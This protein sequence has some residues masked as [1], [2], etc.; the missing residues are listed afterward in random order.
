MKFK[1][2]IPVVLSFCFSVSGQ[3][4]GEFNPGQ[5]S[6]EIRYDVINGTLNNAGRIIASPIKFKLREWAYTGAAAGVIALSFTQDDFFYSSLRGRD[7]S[8]FSSVANYIGEPF[9]N[10][11]WTTG[12]SL[13]LYLLG[14]GFKK[15]RLSEPALIAFQ[16]VAIS[17]SSALFFKLLFHRQR[18]N[19]GTAPDS[20][21]W[22]GP[23][24]RTSNLS[25]PSGHTT[26]AFALASSLATYYK[27]NKSVGILLY[28]LA[29]LT[30]WS[31]VHDNQH[32]FSDVVAGALL[33]YFVGHT[34]A[35]PGLYKWS[36]V[37]NAA[38]GISLGFNYSF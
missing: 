16:S 5:I 8:P 19:E 3:N 15:D 9:G 37:P 12:T 18:P 14:K 2:L 38:G 10:P 11:F 6:S 34:V 29:T 22:F 23:S 1:P 20:K 31:R 17:G 35:T 26:V 33:G 36:L 24:F 30:A 21:A 28:S 25:F 7:G 4:T 27:D 13:G 32:W